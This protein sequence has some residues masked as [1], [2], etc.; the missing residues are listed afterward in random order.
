LAR[1]MAEGGGMKGISCQ[2]SHDRLFRRI[3]AELCGRAQPLLRHAR[4]PVS[5]QS[6]HVPGIALSATFR[7]SMPSGSM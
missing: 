3:A 2:E 4:K 7:K 6:F 5:D 1:V